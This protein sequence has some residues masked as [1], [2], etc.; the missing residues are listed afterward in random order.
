MRT[1]A[2]LAAV[3]LASPLQAALVP[4]A[5]L[6]VAI[7]YGNMAR[8]DFHAEA[9]GGAVVITPTCQV[10]VWNFTTLPG[11]Q[12]GLYGLDAAAAQPAGSVGQIVAQTRYDDYLAWITKAA[13]AIGQRQ[14]GPTAPFPAR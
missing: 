14:I 11:F 6:P 3:L 9:P 4:L 8:G 10:N 12:A 1:T 7:Y 13:A 2:V 5:Q